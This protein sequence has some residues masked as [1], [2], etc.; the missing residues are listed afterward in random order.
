MT[1]S[2]L[3]AEGEHLTNGWEPDVPVD[4]TLK[5]RAVFVHASWPVEVAKA[6]G[7]PWRRTDRWAGAVVGHGGALTN[8]V[9]L[10]QP[11]S[12]ADGVLAEVADLVPTG[13]PYFLL[14][15]WLTPDLAPHGLSLIG[16]PPLMVRLPAPRPRPDPD[17]VEVREALD[18]AALAVAERVLVEGYPMPGTPEGGIF[19]PGLLGGAT[20][21][22][23]GYVD[24]EPVSVA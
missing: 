15:P 11:L 16:H 2:I 24:G 23:V 14:N 12:D 18:P 7:R 20:R 1:E 22:W 17:G 13:T 4:D 3:P 6:L 5:R 9:V 19:A 21:V 10:T 8:A